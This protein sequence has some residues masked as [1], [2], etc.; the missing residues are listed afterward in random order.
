MT[1][2]QYE[3]ILENA[4]RN[5]YVLKPEFLGI[6]L[7]DIENIMEYKEGSEQY[8]SRTLKRGD[9]PRLYE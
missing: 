8:V 2:Y 7:D 4:K 5:I 3:D 6:V 1:N 9:N